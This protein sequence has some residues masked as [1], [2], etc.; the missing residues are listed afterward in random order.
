MASVF[1][2]FFL[3]FP[4]QVYTFVEQWL[5][6]LKQNMK[7]SWSLIILA[8]SSVISSQVLKY[9][10]DV[11]TWENL[12]FRYFGKLSPVTIGLTCCRSKMFNRCMMTCSK[13]SD[14][15]LITVY[16]WNLFA[17]HRGVL[18]SSFR[19]FIIYSGV[20]IDC[21]TKAKLIRLVNCLLVGK[22]SAVERAK[23]LSSVNTHDTQELWSSI[24]HSG[25]HNVVKSVVDL[26]PLLDDM[27]AMNPFFLRTLPVFRI[28]TWS[29]FCLTLNRT[30]IS[31]NIILASLKF[32][33]LCIRYIVLLKEQMRFRIG[34][35][36]TALWT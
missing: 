34:C 27:N 35:L 13:F 18:N 12:T 4:D 22:L 24:G 2:C 26:G 23:L 33:V 32:I 20:E 17:C 11:L 7:H 28:M 8:V 31:V 15:T 21:C 25:S 19:W 16:L 10:G 9:T 29:R 6:A 1:R 3:L 5:H 14:G 30:M 36:K